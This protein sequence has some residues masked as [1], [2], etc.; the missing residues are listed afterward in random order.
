MFKTILVP[1][2]GTPL[3]DKASAA[4]ID[5]AR[6]NPGSRIIGVS[7][8]EK[9][10]FTPHGTSGE[11]LTDYMRQMQEMTEGRV[12]K[13][14][15]AA[16]A[17]GVPC[18]TVVVQA[19]S[20]YEG[21]LKAADEHNCDCIFMASHGRKGLSRLFIGSETQKVLTAAKIPVMVYR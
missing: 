9:L 2:D 17:A 1:T 11:N 19:A 3:S 13:V 5:F 21:I 16:E 14:A 7:V 18:E 15:A 4:A 6:A 12:K 8:V 10:P 20:P